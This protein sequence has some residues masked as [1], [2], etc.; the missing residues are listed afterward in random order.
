[1]TA[2]KAL[3]TGARRGPDPRKIFPIRA[4]VRTED[5]NGRT[6]LV[7]PKDFSL[8]ERKLHSI[9]GGPDVIRRPLDDIGTML[10]NMADGETDLMTIYLAEQEAFD[11][12]VEPVDRVVGGLLETMLK[13]GLMRLEYRDGREKAPAKKAKRLMTRVAK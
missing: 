8:F 10:W 6:V 4:P 7:Y 2:E 13:L 11:E 5:R 1:M 3:D 12:R 9:I